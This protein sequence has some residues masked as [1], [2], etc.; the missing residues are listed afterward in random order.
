MSVQIRGG[1]IQNASITATQLANNSVGTNQLASSS[2]ST[3]KIQANSVTSA[4]LATG[5]INATALIA[6]NIIT[7]DKMDLSGT[8]N[9]SSGTLRAGTPSNAQD[10][11]NKSYVD[12]IVGGGVYWKE[13]ARAASTSNIDL[14]N[15]GTDTFDSITLSSGDRILIKSQSSSA[16]NGVYDFNGSSSALTRSAD[17]NT[18]DE[19][20]G[21]A[22]FVK[23]GSDFGDQGFVQTSEVANIG[24]DNVTFVQFTGL[25]QITA[26]SGLQK[27][28]NT[29]SVD[30]GNGLDFSA[31]EL[32][33]SLGA[34]LEFQS[35][36]IDVLPDESSIEVNSS[37]E[38]QVASNGITSSMIA[39]NAVTG[40]EI[41]A[42]TVG[43]A[44]LGDSSVTAVKLGA[45]AVTEAKIASLSVSEAKIK[46][47]AITASKIASTVAG[48]GLS[49]GGGS[50]LAV[51]VDDSSIEINS[52]SLRV[53][54]LG[55]SAT[56]IA[57]NA[58][59]TNKLFNASVTPQKLASSVAGS[60]LSGGAGSALAVNCGSG[61]DFNGD[62][63]E[64]Q[65]GPGL[66]F[67]SGDVAIAFDNVTIGV[68]TDTGELQVK[69]G[70]I[71]NVKMGLAAVG[72]NNLGS[73]S[74][75]AAKVGFKAYQESTSVSGSS[76]TVISLS[77]AV[78][79]AF[80]DGILAFKNGLA[81]INSTAFGQTAGNND[82]FNVSVSGGV[83]ILTF[84]AAL[85]SGDYILVV[86]TT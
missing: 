43:T 54:N 39:T 57:N 83:T 85:T 46:N 29:I 21:L 50:A 32:V 12:G 14:S 17:A 78:D 77:R 66:E 5:V 23:E 7:A 16:E 53:K 75:T 47:N 55:I 4:K 72:T 31:G 8:F 56:K 34:G 71:T 19:I 36:A 37:G 81:L 26:G 15:P 30:A 20:N 65:L 73:N 59:T 82:Q 69:D 9:F 51:N 44:N 64:V 11:A 60:G 38:L 6:N 22:I 42:L 61:L 79:S 70:S 45:S 52:D 76:T 40:N 62:D 74:V 33:V 1:Q 28:G 80:S 41:A 63:V 2:V 48:A 13:P 84:G 27:S 3:A 58:I 67:D 86:Y 49:G 25:G 24:S 35:G 10:V 18:A 68:T